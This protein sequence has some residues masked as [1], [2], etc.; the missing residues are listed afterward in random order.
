MRVGIRHN[1]TVTAFGDIPLLRGGLIC[2]TNGTNLIHKA[3]AVG[4]D[5]YIGGIVATRASLICIPTDFC[6]GYS[7][8]SVMNVI[9]I[10]CFLDNIYIKIMRKKIVEV[11][12]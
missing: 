7:L 3:M 11:L 12:R 5:F 10:Q 9:M 6:T 4:R 8:G 1:R 2:T